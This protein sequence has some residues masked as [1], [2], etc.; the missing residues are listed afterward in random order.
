MN[1]RQLEYVVAACEEGTFTA[2]AERCHVAQPSLSSS[3]AQLEREVGTLLFHRVGRSIR[4]TPA[5]D[6][7]LPL[8]RDALRALDAALSSVSAGPST[9]RGRVEL[10]VQPTL[11]VRPTI[12]LIERL[13]DRHPDVTVRLMSPADDESVS[14][15][16]ESG[17]CELAIGEGPVAGHLSWIPIGIEE[18]AIVFPPRTRVPTGMAIS[19]LDGR[20][21]VAPP[22]GSPTRAVLDD[23]CAVAGVSPRIVVEADHRDALV[24]L[25]LAG[26]G[27]ALLPVSSLPAAL[28][29]EAT[30]VRLPA[31]RR[32]VGLI[33]RTAPLTPAAT[34]LIELAGNN[35]SAI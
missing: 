27:A 30:V 35:A 33:H 9:V 22:P 13:R 14:D 24:P 21:M 17:R 7:L 19:A 15:L 4:P 1:P 25:V 12:G 26:V 5:C 11:I 20:A 29:S 23:A 34:A 2:A 18:F 16:V 28:P 8:A 10:A 32:T 6:A 31:I 3:I